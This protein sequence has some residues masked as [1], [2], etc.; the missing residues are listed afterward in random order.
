MMTCRRCG[1]EQSAFFYREDGRIIHILRCEK[2]GCIT[3]KVR[4]E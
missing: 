1:H 3:K 4:E 2:C